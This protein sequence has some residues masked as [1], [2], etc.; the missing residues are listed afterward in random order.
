VK[1]YVRQI[2]AEEGVLI[3][4]D[5]IS[6]KPHTD[7]NDLICWHYDHTSGQTI[8]GINFITALYHTQGVALPVD[9]HLVTKTEVYTDKKTGKEKRRSTGTKNETY[10]QLLRQVV[11]N[12]IPVRYMLNDV[13]YASP[14]NMMFVKHD[15][16]HDF[17][18]PLKSNRKV[19]LSMEASR[20]RDLSKLPIVSQ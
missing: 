12:Q 18:M 7:E 8:K 11:S 14:D 9:Y 15:L 10:Q 20:G 6:E 17:V 19:A 2:Q 13:W 5:S 1:P 4:D 16:K 3:I